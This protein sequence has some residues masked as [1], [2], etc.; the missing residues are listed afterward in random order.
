MG[1][2][3]IRQSEK[4]INAETKNLWKV[5][6]AM[7]DGYVLYC[8]T[9]S[10]QQC[11][12]A[13]KYSCAA[14]EAAKIEEMKVGSIVFVYNSD[15]KSLLGPFSVLPEGD[16]LDAGAWSM[17]IDENIEPY[18]DVNVTW[19]ELHILED[20]PSQMPFLK[21]FKTCKLTTTQT[22]RALDLLKQ[23]PLYLNAKNP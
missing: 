1:T 7:Y 3:L 22:Q 17:S 14:K 15:D 5:F 8:T 16:E 9:A 19:E 2:E 18:A 21:D 20:A 12:S 13:K 4:K 6:P 10:L 23:G 11:I